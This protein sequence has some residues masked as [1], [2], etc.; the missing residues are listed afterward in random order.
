MT[1]LKLNSMS[2]LILNR[3]QVFSKPVIW[4][5]FFRVMVSFFLKQR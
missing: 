3:I 4:I 5:C 2:R 1:T